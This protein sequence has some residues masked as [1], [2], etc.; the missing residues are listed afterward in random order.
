M[1]QCADPGRVRRAFVA[2]VRAVRRRRL[3]AVTALFVVAAACA[4][5]HPPST[6]AT[7]IGELG[8]GT[9]T[10][11]TEPPRRTTAPHSTPPVSSATTS[12]PATAPSTASMPSSSFEPTTGKECVARPAGAAPL[13]LDPAA[14]AVAPTS[15][16]APVPGSR[17]LL[18]DAVGRS[19]HRRFFVRRFGAGDQA[20]ITVRPDVEGA[21]ASVAVGRL[22]PTTNTFSSTVVLDNCS[23]DEVEGSGSTIWIAAT[24]TAHA[25]QYP[26]VIAEVDL[27]SPSVRWSWRSRARSSIRHE[28][29]SLRVVGDTTDLTRAFV[30]RVAAGD[31]A[32]ISEIHLDL[33]RGY[34]LVES[35]GPVWMGR[36]D[37]AAD[38]TTYHRFDPDTGTVVGTIVAPDRP[39]V[40]GN[41]QPAFWA[42][43]RGPY[44]WRLI[45]SGIERWSTVDGS[46][47]W[48][49]LGGSHLVH[50]RGS[51]GASGIWVLSAG[52]A[53]GRT[54]TL[55]RIDGDEP[56][57]E[58]TFAIGI[59]RDHRGPTVPVVSDFTV[60]A[61]GFVYRDRFDGAYAWGPATT[62]VYD[63]APDT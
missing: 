9:G 52:G 63:A 55:V 50:P 38:A 20:L 33:E 28:G 6:D 22:D 21:S 47:R 30:A 31:G 60:D 39:D 11:P 2:R 35:D 14:A 45:G 58:P 17:A 46:M 61:L 7:P 34:D 26:H 41:P 42:A 25:K 53:D 44:L 43:V 18:H 4:P 13:V 12:E 36:W 54:G 5:D 57:R 10:V 37:N 62:W 1:R 40:R 27:A 56:I 19:G 51:S 23:V 59:E 29:G 15:V 16:G 8:I 24:S 48:F 32:V 3:L 49:E